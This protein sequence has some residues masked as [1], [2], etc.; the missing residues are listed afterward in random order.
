MVYLRRGGTPAHRG[1]PEHPRRSLP[2]GPGPVRH[3][4]RQPDGH[5]DLRRGRQRGA[6]DRPPGQPRVH[7]LRRPRAQGAAGGPRELRDAVEL[8]RQ[9]RDRAAVRD[10]GGGRG[11]RVRPRGARVRA[12]QRR[13]PHQGAGAGP[14][15]AHGGG[16]CPQRGVRPDRQRGNGDLRRTHRRGDHA[17]DVRC[18]GQRQDA[19]GCGR[20]GL[21][22]R[23]RQAR[24]P[25]L[26]RIGCVHRRLRQHGPA[27]QADR[28]QRPRARHEGNAA[29]RQRSHDV[30]R[31]RHPV[32]LQ[33]AG[34]ARAG[35]RSGCVGRLRLRRHGQ[36][37]LHDAPGAR[38]RQ[39]GVMAGRGHAVG[40][41]RPRG[42]AAGRLGAD[43][44]AGC[45]GRLLLRRAQ[46]GPLQRLRRGHRQAH[47]WWGRRSRGRSGPSSTPRAAWCGACRATVSRS[48]TSTTRTATRR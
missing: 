4:Q 32:L 39:R 44:R 17:A 20:P 36:P 43:Q 42:V 21:G 10:A 30:G 41:P 48:S 1:G 31:P 47:G 28:V 27:A 16:A 15:G 5:E 12:R 13:R 29:R 34:A 23:L 26:R 6:G 11:H 22:V 8:H 7:V 25:D 2:F 24:S 40:L 19:S 33:Q 3:L 37:H 45:D 38:C 18:A 9:H 46:G 35:H 14:A